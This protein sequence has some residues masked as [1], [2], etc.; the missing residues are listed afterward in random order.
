MTVD[1][2]K[3]YLKYKR[4]YNDAKKIKMSGGELPIER[5]INEL[6]D[7]F[8]LNEDEFNNCITN[9]INNKDFT[10]NNITTLANKNLLIV[11]YAHWCT[12][13]VNFIK[14]FGEKIVNY[15]E[16]VNNGNIKFLD[17]MKLSDNWKNK[18]NINGYPTILK[19]DVSTNIIDN[20]LKKEYVGNRSIEDLYIFMND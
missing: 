16:N 10:I 19:I 7:T 6:L 4:K 8:K 18:L 2:K 11:V 13:C 17:G 20:I 1:Y 5:K 12:H 14:E 3:Q 9:H 15:K